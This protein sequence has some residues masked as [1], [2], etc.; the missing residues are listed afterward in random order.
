MDKF[1][2]MSLISKIK[3]K[4]LKHDPEVYQIHN[5]YKRKPQPLN[6]KTNDLHGQYTKA[7]MAAKSFYEFAYLIGQVS[8]RP[9]KEGMDVITVRPLAHKL[10]AHF[11]VVYGE[12]LKFRQEKTRRKQINALNRTGGV[13]SVF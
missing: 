2:A 1:K 3:P 8:I 4:H 11:G 6:V 5:S 7:W 9:N 13:V 12:P 10:D